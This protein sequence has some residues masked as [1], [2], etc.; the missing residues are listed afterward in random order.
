MGLNEFS[1]YVGV[2]IAG[3]LTAYAAEWLGARVGLLVF[4]MAVVLLA[5]L[6]TRRLGE[7]HAAMGQGRDSGAQGR[8]AEIPV[9]L[10]AR[11]FPSNPQRARSSR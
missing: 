6:L 9:A 8:T 7:G 4:G 11:R 2:A 5:L 1:G 10:S 3:I